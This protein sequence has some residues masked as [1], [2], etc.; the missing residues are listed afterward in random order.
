MRS[1]ERRRQ[2][3]DA[4]P[5]AASIRSRPVRARVPVAVIAAL[6]TVAAAAP[7]AAALRVPG[8]PETVVLPRGAVAASTGT[9]AR[10]WLVGVA[11]QGPAAA[12]IARAH[13]ARHVDGRA[14]EAARHPA[15]G[16]ASARRAHGLLAFPQ[17]NPG[18]ARPQEPPP[19][20][21]PP[22]P[23]PLT[24]VPQA[25]WRDAVVGGAAAPPV[26][27]TSPLIAFV[28]SELGVTHPEVAGSNITTTG[29]R[30]VTD[31]HGT[32]TATVAA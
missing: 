24:V 31:F 30:P 9:A 25:G 23:D 3:D 21:G 7:A 14:Y 20:A 11:R 17:A 4:P 16:F 6:S 29:G 28:D 1:P 22:A 13:G 2:R 27:P 26:G 8:V 10:T 19:V 18:S 12:R 32:A 5:S 15:R